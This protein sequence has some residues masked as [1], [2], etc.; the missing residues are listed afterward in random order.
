MSLHSGEKS[1]DSGM[2][3]FS[4]LVS[5][6]SGAIL[7]HNGHFVKCS[8]VIDSIV[9]LSALL[10]ARGH[11]FEQTIMYSFF[12]LHHSG[13]LLSGETRTLIHLHD[14]IKVQLIFHMQDNWLNTICLV[15]DGELS[16]Q[17]HVLDG[18]IWKV[19]LNGPTSQTP[20]D[21]HLFNRLVFKNI[22]SPI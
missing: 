18:C 9:S 3:D 13:W 8:L 7:M 5:K 2:S 4:E 1:D 21:P 14:Q 10:Q 11:V 6:D 20:P 16:Y 12:D 19:I 15:Y 22:E 17:P